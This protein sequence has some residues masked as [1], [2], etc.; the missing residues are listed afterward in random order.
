MAEPPKKKPAPSPAGAKPTMKTGAAAAAPKKP[1]AAGKRPFMDDDT[2]KDALELVR[3]RNDFY[4][5]NYRR[6]IAILLLLLV[7]MFAMSYWIYYLTSHRPSPRYFATN[8]AGGLIPLIPLGQPSI[9]DI[10]LQSWSVRAASA[11]F[12]FNYIQL[13]QQLEVA[14][15]TY[16]TDTGGTAFMDALTSSGDLDA[17]TQG[18]FIVTSQP[19]GAPEIL[20]RGAMNTGAY[21]GHYAWVLRVPM[22]VNYESVLENISSHRNINVQMTIVRT[23]PLVDNAATNIDS[24]QGIGI[25]QLLVQGTTNVMTPQTGGVTPASEESSAPPT[26]GASGASVSASLAVKPMLSMAV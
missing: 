9:S 16:F 13:N 22:Q 14:K 21:K 2:K 1:A 7:L 20:A 6:L 8:A 26:T 25:N 12:T 11:A 4:R 19:T 18:K 3:L 10:A 23:S 24:L 5:D 15:D 17:V